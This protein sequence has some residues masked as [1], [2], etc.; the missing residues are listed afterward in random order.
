MDTQQKHIKLEY[1]DKYEYKILKYDGLSSSILIN[2][3]NELGK[4]GWRAT[5]NLD[6]YD[7]TILLERRI[8]SISANHYEK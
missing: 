1:Y 6:I 3:L 4:E 8:K 2:K 5:K 7:K